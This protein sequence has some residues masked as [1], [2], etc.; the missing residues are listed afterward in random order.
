MNTP[1][2]SI[3]IPTYKRA[4]ML[5]RAIS[6]VLGQTYTNIEVLVVSDNEPDDEYT[7]QARCTIESFHDDRVRLITQERHINGAVARNVGIKASKGQYISFLDDDDYYEKDKIAK[8]VALLN[9]LDVSWGG[10]CCRY[11]VYKN[12]KLVEVM[13]CFKSGKVYKE[14]IMRLIKTQTNCLLLRR[15]ALFKAGLFDERLLRHQD[16]QLI[17]RFT[18][19]Y[20][21][22][23]Q[24][25][26]LNN[27]DQDDN[28]NRSKPEKVMILKLAFFESVKDIIDSFSILEKYR[29]RLLTRFDIGA[30]YIIDGQKLKGALQCLSIL[31]SPVATL[32]SINKVLS[33]K[34]MTRLAR[35]MDKSGLF[36]YREI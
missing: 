9:S 20:K 10:V 35:S 1:L 26:F 32:Q 30:L 4:T 24:N 36:S 11:K 29:F 25:E 22:F 31:L 19:N 28:M 2:T 6:S 5:H 27:L 15:D 12:G 3:I 8:Q 21:L 23:C 33:K 18:Y 14:I 13:P 34:K 16:V 17:A 7:K